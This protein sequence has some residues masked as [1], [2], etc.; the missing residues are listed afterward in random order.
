[1]NCTHFQNNDLEKLMIT[2]DIQELGNSMS[3][4]EDQCLNQYW[5]KTYSEFE[6]RYRLLDGQAGECKCCK[7]IY[8]YEDMNKEGYCDRCQRAIESRC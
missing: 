6:Q 8:N 5:C 7:E 3:Y 1:M 4:C 2:N